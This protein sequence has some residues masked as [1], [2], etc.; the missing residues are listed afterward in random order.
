MRYLFAFLFF[1]GLFGLVALPYQ[2]FGTP[3]WPVVIMTLGASTWFGH[4]VRLRPRQIGLSVG[5]FGLFGA[6]WLK[7]FPPMAVTALRGWTSLLG[8]FAFSCIA[9]LALLIV[10]FK[11]DRADRSVLVG[12]LACIFCSAMIALLSGSS[13][14]AAAFYEFL[15]SRGFADNLAE[16]TNFVFR[17]SVHFGF[18]GFFAV[19]AFRTAR[20]GGA[21]KP[22]IAALAFVMMHSVFDE[23]RQWSVPNRTG[24]AWD[25]L[26]DLLGVL[27]FLYWANRP[28]RVIRV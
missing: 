28:F 10:F 13:G 16:T 9:L 19:M 23:V 17:K 24:S 5:Y 1:A 26:L 20:L 6:L 7:S 18:Y 21:P 22:V 4:I 25:V 8:M 2:T 15:V 3:I 27:A 11:A 12:A 14:G